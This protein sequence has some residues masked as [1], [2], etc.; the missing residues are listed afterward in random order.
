VNSSLLDL[1]TV[2]HKNPAAKK[3]YD[4]MYYRNH[5]RKIIECAKLYYRN[6]RAPRL[7]YIAQWQKDN[8][9]KHRAYT[10][11]YQS[12]HREKYSAYYNVRKTRKTRAGGAY[13]SAQWIALCNKHHNRCVCCGKKRKLTADH[14]L[15][16]SKG[17]S[18]NISNIQPLCGPCNSSKGT[19]TTDFRSTNGTRRK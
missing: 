13:T 8:A 10:S 16:V 1:F 3:K 7:K 5:T 4:L 19:K 11:K 14:V 6:H 18:S 12:E 15:P 17:G 2:P 9:D